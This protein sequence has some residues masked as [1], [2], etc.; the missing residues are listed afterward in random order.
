MRLI[1]SRRIRAPICACLCISLAPLLLSGCYLWPWHHSAKLPE[2]PPVPA[3]VDAEPYRKF[4]AAGD[5]RVYAI[6][7]SDSVVRIY[8]YR[9][10]KAAFAGHNHVILAGAFGGY[11]Y[12]PNK[13]L[14]DARFEVAFPLQGLRVDEPTQRKALGG[15]FGGILPPNAINGTRE[16]MLGER[17]LDAEH[18]PW[19]RIN[20]VAVGGELPKPVAMIALELHGQKRQQLLPLD[21]RQSDDKLRIRGA[22][23]LRQ[24][25]YGLKPYSVLNGLLAV[26]D[27]VAIEFDLGAR[28]VKF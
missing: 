14:S 18:F 21:V 10:G 23:A 13:R 2:P 16:H 15:A 19:V 24:S 22:L 25:D 9:G 26:Q 11:V 28:A 20:S 17:G 12:V 27:D 8:A 1:R 4:D 5:G 6:D 7:A 3:A